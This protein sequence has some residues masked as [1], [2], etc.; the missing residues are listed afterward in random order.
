MP[1][2]GIG[3]EAE[4][5]HLEDPVGGVG[6]D[7]GIGGHHGVQQLAGVR[8]LALVMNALQCHAGFGAVGEHADDVEEQPLA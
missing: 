6:Q 7:G 4:H 3:A 2:L 1:I 8:L 5:P